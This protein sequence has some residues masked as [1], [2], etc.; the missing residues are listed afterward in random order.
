M[1]WVVKQDLGRHVGRLSTGH[2][3]VT[4]PQMKYTCTSSFPAINRNR[5]LPL[6]G[7]MGP[8]I[9][10]TSPTRS[11]ESHKTYVVY[12]THKWQLLCLKINELLMREN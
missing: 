12:P 2:Y 1:S 3:I 6:Q 9:N 10:A 7:H 4:Q 5:C 11:A 8:S